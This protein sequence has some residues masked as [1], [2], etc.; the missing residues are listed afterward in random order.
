MVDGRIIAILPRQ[1]SIID[2]LL[3]CLGESAAV[4]HVILISWALFGSYGRTAR[5]ARESDMRSS[6]V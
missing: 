1:E 5:R 6:M 4:V 3:M 2:A